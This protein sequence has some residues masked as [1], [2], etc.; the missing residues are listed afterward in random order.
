MSR[1]IV[2]RRVLADRGMLIL[3][4]SFLMLLAFLPTR[5]QGRT[6]PKMVEVTTAE[7]LA[8]ALQD[9]VDG[10]VIHLKANITTT[11][12]P[13]IDSPDVTI[14]QSPYESYVLTTNIVVNAGAK[15]TLRNLTL[16]ARNATSPIV[17]VKAQGE[18]DIFGCRFRG[19]SAGT[20]VKIEVSGKYSTIEGGDFIGL[21]R[22]SSFL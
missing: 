14:A 15:L 7:Q 20:G 19:H 5:C 8:A 18:V 22:G 6:V 3:G 4:L 1:A 12:A 10:D 17:E 11:T 21:D 13:E 2:R 16:K 9:P